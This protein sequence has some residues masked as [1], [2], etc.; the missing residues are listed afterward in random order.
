MNLRTLLAGS[1]I[2]FATVAPV[3]ADSPAAA[4]SNAPA[5]VLK[6]LSQCAGI[7]EAPGRLACYDALAPRVKAA[8]SAQP[9]VAANHP[10]TKEE[11]KSWFGFDIGGL[12]GTS[13]EAADHAGTVRRGEHRSRQARRARRPSRARLRRWTASPRRSRNS[14][15]IRSESSSS[16]WTMARSGSRSRAIPTAPVSTQGRGQHGH[17]LARLYRQLQSDDQRQHQGLQGHAHQIASITPG[18]ARPR[19][20]RARLRSAS[21][22][23]ARHPDRRSSS[24]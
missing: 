22:G 18:R 1:A 10:P 7:A 9:A 19:D 4:P 11:Q 21:G 16:S 2:V 24:T 13:P 23:I 8:L 12:F 5:D 14:P 20:G 17:D 15:S 6:A 3:L